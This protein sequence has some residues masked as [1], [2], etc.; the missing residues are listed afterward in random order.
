MEDEISW[1]PQFDIALGFALQAS[2]GLDTIEVAVGVNPEEN[3]RIRRATGAGRL[4]TGKAKPL[5]I[6]RLDECLYDSNNIVFCN[7]VVQM[8]GKENT[9][10]AVGPF[11][12]ALHP[13]LLMALDELLTRQKKS[14]LH[15]GRVFTQPG[16]E[17]E[18]RCFDH[19]NCVPSL[20]TQA[21]MTRKHAVIMETNVIDAPQ[22]QV[23]ST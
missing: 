19:G 22:A 13:A 18:I 1:E 6:K 5:E 9:L 17:A 7:V 10:A 15:L 4:G 21:T 23:L 12:K 8:L 20:A 16:P 3:G 14:R 11:D 2:A